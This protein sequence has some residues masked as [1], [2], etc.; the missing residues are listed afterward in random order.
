MEKNIYLCGCVK[1]CAPFLNKT[2]NHFLT[3][4]K[5]FNEFKI[6]IAFDDSNDNSLEIINDFKKNNNNF[7]L[8]HN[9]NKISKDRVINICNARN[10]IINE[11]NRLNDKTYKYFIMM[12]MDNRIYNKN[13]NTDL[14]K[15]YIIN[16]KEWD[17]LSFN[18][19]G[20][21][22][23]WA[24]SFNPY[25]YSC[26]HYFKSHRENQ[27]YVRCVREKIIKTLNSLDDNT[28]LLDVYSAFN[29]FAIYKI[30]KF[31]NIKYDYEF[32]NTIKLISQDLI[33]ENI[34]NYNNIKPTPNPNK[35]DDCEHR[36]F[37]L[38]AIK[39][40]NAKIKI[41]KHSLFI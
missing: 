18:L 9:K 19:P 28:D 40:N 5:L 2:L 1:N 17:S 30:D 6:I 24:L 20:Y 39:I 29:A 38:N 31:K 4:G 12:D 33:Q 36:Y 25:I 15:K 34:K 21:Y 11:I 35:Y 37:H 22:D 14:L 41:C 10:S 27:K 23:I 16:D 13:I 7:I 26:W 3:I 32:N 8:L